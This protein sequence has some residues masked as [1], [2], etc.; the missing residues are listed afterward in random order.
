MTR[1]PEQDLWAE[2]LLASVTDAIEGACTTKCRDQNINHTQEARDY[3]TSNCED[4]QEVCINAGFDPDA[5]RDRVL[6]MI[7]KAPTPEELVKT[8]DKPPRSR[9]DMTHAGMTLTRKE[10]SERTG[11]PIHI[12]NSRIASNWPVDRILTTPYAPRKSRK[13]A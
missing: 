5:I 6:P 3:I 12:I 10:W 1:T 13:A 11:I 9:K 7:E 4:F 8:E 2:I